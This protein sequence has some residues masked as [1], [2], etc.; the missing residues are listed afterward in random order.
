CIN[1]WCWTV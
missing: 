1:M